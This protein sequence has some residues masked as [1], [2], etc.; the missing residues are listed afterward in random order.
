M[1]R[2]QKF[3]ALIP[4]LWACIFDITITITHQ[5]Q[6]YWQGDLTQAN[7]GNPF[8]AFFMQHHISG[9]FTISALWLV[10]VIMMGYFLPR[11]IGRI[12][13]LFTLIAH[14]F[15]AST[16]FSGG[17]GF[18]YAIGFILFNSI[19]FYVVEDTITKK[20]TSPV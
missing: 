5:P 19:L 9:I 16:W 3:I 6:S 18:W 11:R 8:G 17:Y 15:G 10:I 14:S 12:F 2:K 4:A 1:N 20:T 7:E 13:L